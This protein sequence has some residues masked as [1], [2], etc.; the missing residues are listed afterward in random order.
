MKRKYAI[1]DIETTGGLAKRDKITE[2]A[3]VIHNGTE[4][5]D[6]FDSLINPE[7]SIPPQI[8]RITGI[9]NEMVQDAPKFYE[10]AKQVV[11]ITEGTIFVAHNVRFDYTF[12]KEEFKRLGYNFTKRQLCTVKLTRAT[13]PGIKS[14]SLGNLIQH[15]NIKVEHRHR[16]LD[17]TLATVFVFEQILKTQSSKTDIVDL[18]NLG[19]KEAQ[20]PKG[21]SLDD[22]HE[23]PESCGVY[24]FMNE[25]EDVIYVGKAIDIKARAFQH[26]RATTKK[27]ENLYNR[28]HSISYELTGSELVALLLE[29]REIKRL[30]PEI[31]KAQKKSN[32]PYFLYYEQSE[33]GFLELGIKRNAQKNKLN[34]TSIKEYSKLKIAKQHLMELV[35]EYDLCQ[36]RTSIKN[37]SHICNCMG[38]CTNKNN[39]TYNTL[40]TQMANDVE[41][42]FDSDIILIDEGRE[43][44]EK[45][46]IAIIDG[47]YHGYG[48]ASEDDIHMGIEELLECVQIE[49]HYYPI[50][51]KLVWNHINQNPQ[52]KIIKM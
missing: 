14:Y 35:T 43:K 23:L 4:I 1:I 31:N 21:V 45:A 8:T 33:D 32:F 47:K 24:Y 30:N 26:F 46:I 36:E 2:I 39:G 5:I 41:N 17:D 11:E 51:N 7:R 18:I 38:I 34:R 19:I 13:F 40:V 49:K 20:L 16:A 44:G 25:H 28:V 10:V 29:S 48:Y 15:F 22:L 52:I 27:S 37:E 3:I 6:Q 9:T 50:M 42:L 12:I